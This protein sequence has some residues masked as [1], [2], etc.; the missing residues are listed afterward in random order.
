MRWAEGRGNCTDKTMND[1]GK[2]KVEVAYALPQRQAIVP[3]QVAPGTTAQQAALASNLQRQFPNLDIAEAKLGVF[4]KAVAPD[5]VLQA[6]ERVE[7]YRPLIAD[8]KQV[9]KQRAA[10][11]RRRREKAPAAK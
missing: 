4:G 1:D 6:G 3:L 9:R 5:Y 2:I 8:P 11:Q 10:E 7:I